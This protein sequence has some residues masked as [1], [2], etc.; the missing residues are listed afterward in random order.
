MAPM[1]TRPTLITGG[2]TFT[3]YGYFVRR[4]S[5]KDPDLRRVSNAQEWLRL[6]ALLDGL[7]AGEF[8]TS[9]EL[10]ELA[11][12]TRDW[13]L[14]SI[15]IK[16]LGHCA[17]AAVYKEMRTEIEGF[18]PGA[19]GKYHETDVELTVRYCVA[20]SAWGR[21]DVIPVILD[22]YLRLKQHGAAEISILPI[23]M[24]LLMHEELGTMVSSEPP[25][26]RL[27]EYLTVV[28]H[29][30]EALINRIGSKSLIV[31]GG[32]VR[33][34]RHI[35]A[36]MVDPVPRFLNNQFRQLRE[37]FEPATGID[38]SAMF[39]DGQGAQPQAGALIGRAF[40]ESPQAS[41]FAPG[42]RYFFGHPVLE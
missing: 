40:L 2:L 38:C 32:K 21:A 9:T 36:S 33:S 29:E 27:D 20:F 23:L 26:D 3:K 41:D 6:E 28:L 31:Y 11:R 5:A 24:G 16:T 4:L 18:V 35:A 8:N 14:K 17:T 12:S 10:L 25:E 34:I 37:M 42:Q 15:A 1:D 22:R 19:F 7:K 39:V 13:T 30:Y